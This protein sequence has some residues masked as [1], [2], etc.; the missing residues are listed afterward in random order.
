[1]KPR[2][3]APHLNRTHKPGS[4]PSSS[5]LF[6]VGTLVFG[7]TCGGAFGQ[8]PV[9]LTLT[10][11]TTAYSENFNSMPASGTFAAGLPAGWY[12]TENGTG[13]AANGAY[14]AGTGSG[15]GGDTY[16]FASAA[17]P[18]DRALGALR[19]GTVIPVIGAGFKNTTGLAIAAVSVSYR[20]EQWRLGTTGRA[21]KWDFQVST[22]ATSLA[23]GNWTDVNDLDFTAPISTGTAGARD[24]NLAANSVAI[25]DKDIV[26]SG[27]V[28]NDANFFIRWNDVDVSGA[29]DGLAVD[30]FSMLITKLE[31][32]GTST[33]ISSL[34]GTADVTVQNGSTTASTLTVAKASGSDTFEGKL[35]D[36][37]AGDAALSLTKSGAG[38]LI[39]TSAANAYTGVTLVS[40]GTL[41]LGATG[42]TGTGAVT[43][44]SGATLNGLGTVAGAATIGGLHSV[45]SDTTVGTQAFSSSLTYDSSSTFTW[46]LASETTTGAG[47]NF[48]SVT[49][50][51]GLDVDG[52]VFKIVV[53]GLDLDSS[54]WATNKTWDIFESSEGTGTFSSYELYDGNNVAQTYGSYGSFSFNA[55]S[56]QLSWSAVPEPTNALAGLLIG[57]GLLRR[58][59]GAATPAN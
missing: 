31:T 59:R 20:G 14:I 40:E 23:T 44:S 41:N 8:T 53:T 7:A 29:D 9:S 58:R 39:L 4:L 32:D 47:T 15:T 2:S 37:D 25:D 38:T 21:D 1:M 3:N 34:T 19:S 57:A 54:F 43:V 13:G 5:A 28:A 6:A 46:N 35:I 49:I 36:G 45:G 22:N 11:T 27:S 24:G 17:A 12:V 50:G 30:D 26:F 55:G 52:G 42:R 33:S 51:G 56:G 48:D 10:N 18:T 16:A